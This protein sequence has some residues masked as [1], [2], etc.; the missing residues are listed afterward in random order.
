MPAPAAAIAPAP[1][2]KIAAVVAPAAASPVANHEGHDHPVAVA[3]NPI[4]DLIR[5]FIGDGTAANPNG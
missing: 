4:A 5:T 3:A 2:V 1:A